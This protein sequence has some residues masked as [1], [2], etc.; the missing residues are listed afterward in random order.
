MK[1]L[2]DYFVTGVE[3]G[4]SARMLS[5]GK[6]LK[7]AAVNV[8]WFGGDSLACVGSKTVLPEETRREGVEI[9]GVYRE[10]EE[11]RCG[12]ALDEAGEKGDCF[13]AEEQ[14]CWRQL[15]VSN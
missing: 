11:S 2:E 13:S 14:R 9:M 12:I 6:P 10:E 5:R 1:R 7:Q 3:K 4:K 8:F 15:C